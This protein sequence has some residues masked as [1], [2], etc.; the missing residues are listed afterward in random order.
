MNKAT[1][2]RQT[3]QK[4]LKHDDG[5]KREHQSKRN[6]DLNK[7]KCET[8][9]GEEIYEQTTSRVYKSNFM[10]FILSSD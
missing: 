5:Y 10:M 3:I 1:H 8:L 2:L 9:D 6:K 4:A 7:E